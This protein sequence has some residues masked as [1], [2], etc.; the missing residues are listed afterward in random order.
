M[1]LFICGTVVT[2]P[3]EKEEV[4]KVLETMGAD[5]SGRNF[6]RAMDALKE[7]YKEQDRVREGG[8]DEKEVDWHVHL[9][10]KGLL[11]FSL[12]GI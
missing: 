8:G 4:L 11:D 3:E 1:A 6:V 10:D 12:F 5:A 2:S 9:R 7:L